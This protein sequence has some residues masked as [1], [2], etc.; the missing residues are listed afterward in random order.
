[1]NLDALLEDVTNPDRSKCK[2]GAWID[3]LPPAHKAA[4]QAKLD[5]SASTNGLFHWL[6]NDVGVDTFVQSTLTRHRSGVC[7]CGK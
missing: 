2:V 3:S 1:M 5:S 6:R 7:S 4:L